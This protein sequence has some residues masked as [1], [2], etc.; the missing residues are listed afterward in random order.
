MFVLRVSVLLLLWERMPGARPP[1]HNSC[2]YLWHAFRVPV[3]LVGGWHRLKAGIARH[4]PRTDV[5]GLQP[6][7]RKY[8]QRPCCAP[9]IVE[10]APC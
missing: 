1:F 6:L 10:H 2:G 3:S 9:P 8:F 7:A 4:Q 5:P